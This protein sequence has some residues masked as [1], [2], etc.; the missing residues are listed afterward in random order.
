MGI[1]FIKFWT[2]LVLLC[3]N[4]LKLGLYLFNLALC[5]DH[6]LFRFLQANCQWFN[7]YVQS[8]ILGS[9]YYDLTVEGNLVYL[10]VNDLCE[11]FI[12][13]LQKWLSCMLVRVRKMAS[14]LMF[15]SRKIW[16]NIFAF[17]HNLPI[18]ELYLV[19]DA[20]CG[21]FFWIFQVIKWNVLCF[22]LDFL[23]RKDK[24]AAIFLKIFSSKSLR[25]EASNNLS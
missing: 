23:S 5:F 1:F 4:R 13:N 6:F 24:S 16:L 9:T 11:S 17:H 3:L 22:A 18:A 21:G 19:L 20:L 12:P 14:W 10:V 25:G 15:G 8:V 2:H 7:F